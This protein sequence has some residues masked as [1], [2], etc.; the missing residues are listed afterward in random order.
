MRFPARMSRQLSRTLV[1]AEARQS[2]NIFI[3]HP[4]G[5]LTDSRAHGDGLLTYRFICELARRG[6]TLSVACEHVEIRGELPPNITLYPLA[7]RLQRFNLM[8]RVEY[9]WKMRRLFK[10]LDRGRRF[11]IA[12][13]L[14]PVYAG[15]SLGLVGCN[16]PLVLGP[17]VAH[18]PSS[19]SAKLRTALLDFISRFQQ[20]FADAI[21]VAGP[22]ARSRIVSPRIQ[23]DQIFTVPYGI[24]LELFAHS[25]PPSGDPVIL[26]L[27]ALSERKGILVLLAAFDLIAAEFPDVRLTIGGDGVEGDRF[28]QLAGSSPY[29]ER[30]T[31]LGTV[32]RK[33]IPA[34]LAASTLYVLASYSEPYGMSL[35]EAM[36]TGRPVIATRAGGP[37]DL[38]DEPGGL[39]VEPGDIDALAGAL[40]TLLSDPQ[41]A[42]A[43]GAYNRSAMQRYS[44]PAV[45]DRLEAVYDAAIRTHTALS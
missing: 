5:V 29:H 45:I 38:V 4:S 36:A 10:R 42:R 39:L 17:Y 31:F 24:D 43:M 27:A 2:R 16:I 33:D 25:V 28:R 30:I 21:V 1:T 13:Q 22:A 3:V 19:R 12:H 6:H 34:T 40:R 41:R 20:R 14:N 35:I 37:V 32:P 44:W 11:D 8:R 26:Y 23:S 18:W 9:A 15:L 7:L